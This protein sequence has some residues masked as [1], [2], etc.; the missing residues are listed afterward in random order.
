LKNVKQ[1]FLERISSPEDK[2]FISKILDQIQLCTKYH[3]RRYTDFLDPRQ[4]GLLQKNLPNMNDV[5]FDFYGGYE[6]AERKMAV[7]F[8]DYMES[9]GEEF[10][11]ALLEITGYQVSRLSHRD[12]L[13]AILGLGIKRE[14]IGDIIIHNDV[15][16]CFC[17]HDIKDYIVMNLKKVGSLTVRVR[18]TVLEDVILPEK[19]YKMIQGT[20][21]SLRLDSVISTGLGESRN[22]SVAY[23]QSEKVHVNWEP[24]TSPSYK[25]NEGDV[26]SV[27]GHGRMQVDRVG[28]LTRKGRISIIIKRYI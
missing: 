20:V 7:F 27:R 5:K 22:K 24:V 3:E 14:K 9:D 18:E 8:P 21:S 12:F 13:G 11:I 1:G 15:C 10:P 6:E 23:I 25:V 17:S 19:K 16:Y 4:Q 28:G 2:L 26:I